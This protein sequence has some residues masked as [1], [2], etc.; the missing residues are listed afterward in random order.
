MTNQDTSQQATDHE[1][2]PTE[3]S[4]TAP[5]VPSATTDPARWGRVDT[6]GTVYVTTAAG[7]RAVGSWQAGDA[8]EGLAHFARKFDDLRT[9]AELLETRLTTQAGDPKQALSSAHHLL[10]RVT[11]ADAVGDLDALQARVQHV[12]ARAE[13]AAEQ[14]KHAKEQARAEA[15]GRKEKLVAEAEQ[16]A[17]ESTNWKET[18]D[19]LRHMLDEWKSIRGVD[20]KTDE[21]LWR[22]F[23]KARD[24]FS[25]RRGSHFAEL[26]RQRSAAKARKQ[27]LVDEAESLTE[28][29]AWG[30]TA[31]RYKHLMS[32]WK[33]AGRAPKDSEEAL[34][35]RFRTAQDQFFARRSEAFS[36]RDAEFEE[37]ARRK[38]ELLGEAEQ[39]DPNQDLKAAQQQVQRIQ[40]QWDEIGK[41][42]RD[43]MK[44]L[45][46]RLRAVVDRVRSTAD[47]QWRRT[48]PEAQARVDQFRERVAQYE[49]QADKARSAGDEKRAK[50]ADEQAQQWREWLAAAERALANR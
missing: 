48:D 19:R 35:K 17:A 30:E 40:R 1:P 37:N 41:V 49:D 38:E 46:G 6:A 5:V 47:A 16:L 26:D 42:P 21:Q 31:Q 45:E 9:E 11:N 7:E 25:R 24:A 4:Q 20:R 8:G 10:E 2:R 32:E 15:T 50:K 3:P 22:R 13:H 23:A 28:S 36:A 33:A 34:W 18:G 14:A 29:T 43:R 39:I 12:I 27:E 44:E